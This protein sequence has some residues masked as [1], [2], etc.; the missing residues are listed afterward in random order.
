MTDAN[1]HDEPVPYMARTRQYYR[2]MGY[3]RDYTWAEH[4]TIPFNRSPGTLRGMRIT[5]IST[6][7]PPDWTGA[8]KPEDRHVCT[9]ELANLP[10]E[11]AT[12]VAWDRESTHVRDPESYVPV[13]ALTRLASD[14]LF[15]TLTPRLISV[16]TV[17]SSRRTLEEDAP[18]VL[19][20]CVEDGTEAAVLTAL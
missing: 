13:R 11:F 15:G 9:T 1:W 18:K 5:L 8:R 14:G 7:G 6:A 16:P 19:A 3:T 4:D 2:A 20:A 10:Q 12:N 17:Y